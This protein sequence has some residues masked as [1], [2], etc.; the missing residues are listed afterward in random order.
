VA[1]RQKPCMKCKKQHNLNDCQDFLKLTLEQR[2]EF[3]QPK[4]LC[5]GCL[6]WGHVNRNCRR[7]SVCK[8]CGKFHPTSLHDVGYKVTSKVGKKDEESSKDEEGQ[9]P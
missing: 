2:K 6:T 9:P 3:V 5:F 1:I 4:G 8:I 7:K